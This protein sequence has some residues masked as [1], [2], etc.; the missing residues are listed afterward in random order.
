MIV[1][2]YATAQILFILVS[3]NLSEA[4]GLQ[5][6]LKRSKY[7]YYVVPLSDK[8]K[9]VEAVARQI[10]RHGAE[11]PAV[12]VIN[13]KF[14]GKYC[15]PLL[16]LARDATKTTAIECVITYPPVVSSQREVLLA[17]GARLFDGDAGM[18]QAELT[19][20]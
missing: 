14:A 8:A 7:R 16:E 3:D 2:D 1:Q 19:L 17:L 10:A 11:M 20:H 9:L 18:M 6:D 5:R 4:Q 13:C 12:L 15:K